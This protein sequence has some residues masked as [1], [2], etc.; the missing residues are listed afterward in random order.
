MCLFPF[1]KHRA[2][3][4]KLGKD[5][6]N[7]GF[8]EKNPLLVVAFCLVLLLLITFL[9]MY[10]G[11]RFLGVIIYLLGALCVFGVNYRYHRNDKAIWGV[12]VAAIIAGF[13]GFL[14]FPESGK[15]T[16]IETQFPVVYPHD[17]L[18]RSSYTYDLVSSREMGVDVDLQY[19]GVNDT[20]SHR[21][22]LFEEKLKKANSDSARSAIIDE[23]KHFA[24]GSTQSALDIA[25]LLYNNKEY[26]ATIESLSEALR[27][28]DSDEYAFLLHYNMAI[29][30]L[31]IGKKE[32]AF[33]QC[34]EA[35]DCKGSE[36]SLIQLNVIKG[37]CLDGWVNKEAYFKKA[38]SISPVTSNDYYIRGTVF[39]QMYEFKRA[40]RNYSKAIRLN[41]S[42]RKYRFARGRLYYDMGK[43][44]RAR[45]DFKEGVGLDGSNY[46]DFFWLGMASLSLSEYSE[47]AWYFTKAVQ[48][49]SSFWLSYFFRGVSNYLAGDSASLND[50]LNDFNRLSENYPSITDIRFFRFMA[51][52]K[53]MVG[54]YYDE[55]NS[56]RDAVIHN[57]FFQDPFH[58]DW[59]SFCSRRLKN[60]IVNLYMDSVDDKTG[61]GMYMASIYGRCGMMRRSQYYFRRARIFYNKAISSS[62]FVHLNLS[63]KEAD[64]YGFI[65]EA[66]GLYYQ[67]SIVEGF[68]PFATRKAM[69]DI[70][71]AIEL[72]PDNSRLYYQRSLLFSDRK[73]STEER[74]DLLRAIQLDSTQ[75]DYYYNLGLLYSQQQAYDSAVYYYQKAAKIDSSDFILKQ[76]I[77]INKSA[78]ELNLL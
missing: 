74:N 33:K 66:A 41:P 68:N 69:R 61:M 36:T 2:K 10:M 52:R 32:D 17:S 55:L 11:W 78:V 51:M 40:I 30:Y 71:K 20:C 57:S 46:K 31:A 64:P 67:R 59:W 43:I 34:D 19:N 25:E 62:W 53:C 75:Y 9:V 28:P 15:N 76:S 38:L 65:H 58:A 37:E 6:I 35:I 48:N 29:S 54:D 24:P 50:A 47:S 63:P 21:S 49:D 7:K 14:R 42:E 13:V 18:G 8:L 45:R 1:L 27:Y 4:I 16:Q 39:S 44:R 77:E 60:M 12:L 70:N 26:E 56:W 5:S 72:E 3:S 73:K 23:I 22:L